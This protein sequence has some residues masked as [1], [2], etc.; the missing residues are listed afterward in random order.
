[1]Y[2]VSE[3]SESDGK[4]PI[5]PSR[6]L[7]ENKCAST[8]D[9]KDQSDKKTPIVKLGSYNG[10]GILENHLAKFVNIAEYYQW[11]TRDRLFFLKSSL[12]GPATQL[13]LELTAGATEAGVIQLLRNRFGCAN[14]QGV[15][16]LNCVHVV[17]DQEKQCKI[18]FLILCDCYLSVTQDSRENCIKVSAETVFSKH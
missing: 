4:Q 16:V 5:E 11:T 6:E 18:C 14:Q 3:R 2:V 7:S 10:T 9:R 17:V 12:N 8:V 15:S 1:M 13:L